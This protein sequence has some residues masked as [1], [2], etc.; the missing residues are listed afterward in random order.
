M[1]LTMRSTVADVWANPVGR[2]ALGKIMLQLGRGP[3]WITNPV[4]SRLRL[5]TLARLAA[6]RVPESFFT[7]LL[8]LLNSAPDRFEDHHGPGPRAWW[9]EAVF[10]QV[11]P[12]SF[13]DSD[14][15]GVGDLGGIIDG[16]DH[17][18]S[19]GVDALWLSPVYDSP[20]DDN[21]YDIRD[22]LAIMADFGTMEDFDR[23]LTEVH[24]RGMRL[25]MDLVVNHTSDE[26]RWFQAALADQSS[27]YRDYYVFRDGVDGG[28]PN[29]WTSFFSGSA[30]KQ[31]PDG[32]YA[33]HLFS[34]KQMDLN[35]ENAA[36]RGEIAE[37][38]RWWLA[39]G[40]DGFRL[41]VIN[42]ISKHDGLP[43]GDTT[44]AALMGY[45]GVE[46][47]FY[48]P[49]LHEYLRELRA[50]AFDPYDAFSVG[51]TPG[52]GMEQAAL[53]TA[54]YRR[55]LDMVF[56]FDHLETPGHTRF[57]D[58]RY[59]LEYLK[60]Y[61]I[62]WVEQ[63]PSS[64]WMALF[65]DNH[66]NPRMVSK[67][68]PD[69]AHREQLGDG[70]A[71]LQLTQRGTPF[72]YQGQEI[73]M[74]NQR[75]A[76]ITRL[77][78]VESQNLY[79]EL[80]T[81]M[82]P[83]QAFARVLAGS[84]DHSRVPLQWTPGPHGGFSTATPWLEGDGDHEQCNVADQT[85]DPTSVLSFYRRLI[86]MRKATPALVY[87][88]VRFVG[89]ARRGY[90]GYVRLLDGEA[91]LV[92]CNLTDRPRRVPARHARLEYVL[93]THGTPGARLR[94][95]EAVIYRVGRA[96]VATEFTTELTAGLTTGRASR[97]DT[98]GTAAP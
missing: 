16:L 89:R 30:W 29:N 75:F 68:D 87:G 8:R 9:K 90:F 55:E 86:G 35:W 39:K 56:S 34:D 14:G 50:A 71:V 77:R 57:D 28:P 36:L 42:Y 45:T 73:G 7:A 65:W 64:C 26:H 13:K 88:D 22:Y 49:R 80:A 60:R 62:R 53:L 91:Y 52:I 20:N 11:Y 18:Q 82:S 46:N 67:V 63:Y 59:D 51:E 27:P 1:T 21:G 12:R 38:V 81:T 44:I 70:V 83:E 31:V 15:D 95:Y 43:P 54:S 93:G 48:G 17:L 85:A 97:Q 40:V 66:D 76:D 72:L 84:R 47:Y 5:D 98:A 74:V 19:L 94:P 92:E 2:D 10:Y 61:L 69:P 33:L 41:D 96:D 4:V 37:T 32:Q 78:D 24:A 25:I 58:Y 23:L 79:D 3:G 6:P